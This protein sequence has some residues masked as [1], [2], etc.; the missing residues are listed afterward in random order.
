MF[1]V[2]LL[3]G[4]PHLRIVWRHLIGRTA[5]ECEVGMSRACAKW[6]YNNIYYNGGAVLLCDSHFENKFSR[7]QE[8]FFF[9]SEINGYMFTYTVENKFPHR[10]CFQNQLG[11]ERHD[12]NWVMLLIFFLW[13]V[14]LGYVNLAR[15]KYIYCPGFFFSLLYL[16]ISLYSGNFIRFFWKKNISRKNALPQ[17]E[18]FYRILFLI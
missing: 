3:S 15:L 8:K 10:Y 4:S 6:D 14:R 17:I 13:N 2:L 18:L 11:L 7:L 9:H 12:N 5:E 1:I 16:V